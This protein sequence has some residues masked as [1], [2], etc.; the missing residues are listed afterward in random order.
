MNYN[1]PTYTFTSR[2]IA[3]P[4][5]YLSAE[6]SLLDGRLTFSLSAMAPWGLG[7]YRRTESTFRGIEQIRQSSLSLSNVSLG[8]SFRFGKGKAKE[9]PSEAIDASG[10]KRSDR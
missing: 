8:V 1:S 4:L 9:A 3:E 10:L 5:T 7:E 6:K 2:T